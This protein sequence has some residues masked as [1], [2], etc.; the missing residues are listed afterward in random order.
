MYGNAFVHRNVDMDFFVDSF[1]VDDADKASA[2]AWLDGFMQLMAP[3]FNGEVYQN[4]PRR[5]TPGYRQAY[6]GD[7]FAA[8]LA[9]KL[10]YN[11]S[12]L[13]DFEQSISAA[14]HA[15]GSSA[16][17]VAAPPACALAPEPYSMPVPPLQP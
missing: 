11:R 13:L 3:Y 7:A 5:N 16:V 2:V 1:W 6:W 4:Y 15:P 14:P 17:A 10:R 9:C 12:T 8:L